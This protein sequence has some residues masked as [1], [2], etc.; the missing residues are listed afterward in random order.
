[1]GFVNFRI[2]ASSM[3]PTLTKGD[4]ILVSTFAYMSESPRRGDVVVFKYPRNPDIYYVKRIVGLGGDQVRMRM[5][6]VFVNDQLQN[7]PYAQ[8][9]G[10]RAVKPFEATVPEQHY[11]VLGDNRVNSSDSRVWGYVPAENIVGRVV[12]I[13]YSTYAESGPVARGEPDKQE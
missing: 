11:F 8:Y 2:P 13:V 6:K 3:E 10:N 12:R 7:E 4:F 5:D 1:M 9:L